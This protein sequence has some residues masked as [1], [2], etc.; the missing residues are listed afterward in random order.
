M[1]IL[2][3]SRRGVSDVVCV[4]ASKK[5]MGTKSDPIAWLGS[6]AEKARET[7]SSEGDCL[8]WWLHVPLPLGTDHGEQCFSFKGSLR[9]IV[10]IESE[11]ALRAIGARKPPLSGKSLGQSKSQKLE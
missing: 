1:G 7:F 2:E 9:I 8:G 4:S 11:E 5:S 10:M 3:Q 6:H